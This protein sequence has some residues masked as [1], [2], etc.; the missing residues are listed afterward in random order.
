M[1]DALGHLARYEFP[2]KLNETTKNYPEAMSN[3]EEGQLAMDMKAA[4]SANPDPEAVA[5]LSSKPLYNSQLRTTCVATMLEGGHAY[6]ALP[7]LARATVNCRVLPGESVDDVQK[8]LIKVIA[9]DK[10]AMEQVGRYNLSPPSALTPEI[11]RAM[12][13][14]SAEFWPGIPLLQI[15]S[16]GATDGAYLRSAGIPTF[17]NSGLLVDIYDNRFH[18][19]DERMGVK[20]FYDG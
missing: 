20:S 17:G 11:E 19:K 18:G 8:T 9:D 16:P 3:L 15:M 5:R 6:N 14:L 13:D 4:M 1:A 12:V 7:Q 2:V 10:I